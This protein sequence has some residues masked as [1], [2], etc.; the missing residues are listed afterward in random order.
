MP[1]NK[2]YEDAMGSVFD[3]IFE[4]SKQKPSKVRPV[5]PTGVDGSAEYVDALATVLESPLMFVN[6]S[7]LET[8]QSATAVDLAAFQVGSHATDKIKINVADLQDALSD[9]SK[10]IDKRFQKLEMV[11]QFTKLSWAGEEMKGII[12]GVWAK[13][14]GLDFETQQALMSSGKMLNLHTE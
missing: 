8:F 9:P 1:K 13:Q 11:R 12:G 4:Q 5:K 6:N 7:A 14:H 3:F 2:Q 10:F